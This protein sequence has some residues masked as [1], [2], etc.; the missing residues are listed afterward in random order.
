M[1]DLLPEDRALIEA[2][3][4]DDLPTAQD[5]DRVRAG[6]SAQ[7]GITVA[8]AAGEGAA[9]PGTKTAVAAV[10]GTAKVVKLAVVLGVVALGGAGAA[11]AI[12]PRTGDLQPSSSVAKGTAPV[13]IAIVTPPSA[14][15]PTTTDQAMPVDQLPSA[16]AVSPRSSFRGT[17][18][19][20]PPASSPTQ[21]ETLPIPPRDALAEE[22]R[23]LR[24]ANAA[25]QKGDAESALSLLSEHG[26]RFPA[27][28]LAEERDV[29]RVLALCGAGRVADA[30]VEATR[31]LT[32]RPRSPLAGRVRTSCGGTR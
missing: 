1:S 21:G 7:F 10:S 15:A 19:S 23:I 24:E 5:R 28:V 14:R 29:E 22:T 26:R 18:T 20:L 17:R 30:R 31:F 4:P 32:D 8:G 9:G 27:G 16:P 2:G 12:A 13:P 25:M 3:A 6:L 11:I